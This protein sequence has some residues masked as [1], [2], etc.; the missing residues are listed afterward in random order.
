MKFSKFL[1]E[2]KSQSKVIVVYGGGFQPFHAGHMSSYEQAKSAFPSA[3]FYVASSNDTKQ[4][5]IPFKDKQFLAQQAG[6]TD[7]FVQVIQPVNPKEILAQYNPK[8]D[9]LILVRSER[10]PVNYTKKDG[11][12][13]YYQPYKSLKECKPFDEKTGHGYIFVTKKKVF[14][15]NGKEVYSGSQV[16]EMYAKADDKA[17][18]QMISQLYP[19]AKSPEK[20]KSLLDKYIGEVKESVE[21]TM[22]ILFENLLVEGVHD[23]GIFKAV[24]LAGGP[25]SGK[26]FV[27]GKTLAGNGLTEINSDNAFEFLMDKKRLNKKM[28]DS[29]KA[30]RDEI[31]GTAKSVTELRQR[32]ALNGRNGL[33][34]NGTADDIEKTKRIK[35]ELED[36]GYETQMVFVDTADEVSRQRNIE[37]GQRGGRE[38]PEDIRKEKWMSAQKARP[39]LQKLFG[40]NNFFHY[41]NS[42]D[43]RNASPEVVHKKTQELDGIFKNVRKFTSAPP[44]S[45]IAKSWISTE[46]VRKDK[47]VEK[48]LEAKPVRKG[49]GA[50]EQASKLGLTYYGFGRYGKDRQITHHSVNDELVAINKNQPVPSPNIPTQSGSLGASKPAHAKQ[51]TASKLKSVAD[52]TKPEMSPELKGRLDKA[53]KSSTLNKLKAAEKGIRKEDIDTSFS[54]LIG[55]SF[56]F[57][58]NSSMRMLMLGKQ[59]EIYGSNEEPSL[60]SSI[61][62]KLTQKI[63]EENPHVQSNS[64]LIQEETR[65]GSSTDTSRASTGP[66]TTRQLREHCGCET[67]S[68]EEGSG[69]ETTIYAKETSGE[70]STRKAGTLSLKE[71]KKKLHNH[72]IN[73]DDEFEGKERIT[74]PLGTASSS[75]DSLG[76]VT[77]EK[78][79]TITKKESFRGR[80]TADVEYNVH[81]EKG[82]HIRTTKTKKEAKVWA[83]MHELSKEDMYKKYPELRPK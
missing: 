58:D 79:A 16:R 2:A 20:V 76:R 54:E 53:K 10:D 12:K 73:I 45:D 24:F 13:A 75:Y 60:L 11:S 18:R 49:S 17:K 57:S 52:I 72:P 67:N 35:K 34:I 30:Q 80:T 65:A 1:A 44:K 7:K 56:E 9:I 83:D 81:D 5:P 26:D 33:I 70:K 28:P 14:Q 40:Q 4:R 68:S 63:K 25:G 29:E 55:E 3:D 22:D 31:R 50:G 43:L 48:N 71:I 36:L 19:H 42:E 78:K 37:R 41:D 59:I 46:L 51:P 15:L 62:E 39:E 69:K 8:K 6:V 23:S 66:R 61:K 32:L 21:I 77:E 82:N 38:V 74:P 64:R 27:M 47:T